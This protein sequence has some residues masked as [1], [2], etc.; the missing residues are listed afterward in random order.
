MSSS[1][2][3]EQPV[4]VP[5]DGP[6]RVAFV[7]A[8]RS[9]S[10]GNVNQIV[11]AIEGGLT[12]IRLRQINLAGNS[13]NFSLR[14]ELQ[15]SRVVIV[16]NTASFRA[17]DLEAVLRAASQQT[18]VPR[19][20]VMKQDEYLEP[21]AFDRLFVDFGV[22][23]VLSCLQP[24]DV[25]VVY[26][27]STKVGVDFR[28]MTTAYLPR[29]MIDAPVIPLPDQLRVTHR[30]QMEPV[31]L[32]LLGQQKTM[33]PTWAA[34]SIGK[35]R[36][37]WILDASSDA[38][39]RIYGGGWLDLMER[40][41]AVL[42]SESGTNAFD[43]DGSL[44]RRTRKFV[45]ER[46]RFG[47][48]N[49]AL[50]QIYT[51]EILA[52]YEGNVMYGTIAPRHLEAAVLGRPQILTPGR[53]EN[54]FLD[55]HS[56][57]FVDS[58]CSNLS[59][60]LGLV[61]DVAESARVA[62][63]ARE[64]VLSVE[65]LRLDAFLSELSTIVRELAEEGVDS[66]IIEAALTNEQEQTDAE[67]SLVLVPQD[68]TAASSRRLWSWIAGAEVN[69]LDRQIWS[70]VNLRDRF[71]GRSRDSDLTLAQEMTGNSTPP[72]T[73]AKSFGCSTPSSREVVAEWL[74]KNPASRTAPL[75]SAV[76]QRSYNE[77][78]KDTFDWSHDLVRR[79]ASFIAATSQNDIDLLIAQG[80][81]NT[82]A[83]LTV[84]G[85]SAQIVCDL[86]EPEL[87]PA[88]SDFENTDCDSELW[89]RVRAH[90]L[91]NA[92][93]V[94]TTCRSMAAF[95]ER[96]DE[97]FA[98]VVSPLGPRVGRPSSAGR[99]G[100]PVRFV[101]ITDSVRRGDGLKLVSSWKVP[102]EN[103]ELHVLLPP[104]ELV[105]SERKVAGAEGIHLRALAL[106][107]T[108]SPNLSEFDVGIVSSNPIY[109]G[110]YSLPVAFL[111]YLE[112]GLAVLAN[113]VESTTP[114][115]LGEGLGE[116]FCWRD[117]ES[118]VEAAHRLSDREIAGHFRTTVSDSY[119]FGESLGL[120]TDE[121]LRN[122]LDEGVPS[123]VKD[124]G[125][126]MSEIGKYGVVVRKVRFS[127][128]RS[129]GLEYLRLQR[130][131]GRS[132]HLTSGLERILEI[133]GRG[134][135]QQVYSRTQENK[136]LARPFHWIG[137]RFL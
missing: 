43:M 38:T 136:F 52:D 86:I 76:L 126:E 67:R 22:R 124:G 80:V 109:P 102:A 40:S 74:S 108:G 130:S 135:L 122:L 73:V 127:V 20:L 51:K 24:E 53:Y 92:S 30:G 2:Q 87:A 69:D 118:L 129:H 71:L 56:A 28:R 134:R 35:A 132:N 88:Y 113:D 44:R 105:R 14:K 5:A 4:T 61:A 117:S 49:L 19:F 77:K 131:R 32:G 50:A 106:E 64:T 21:Y 48:E 111:E 90:S 93:Q 91:Q 97:I 70:I 98:S 34:E 55:G 78:K 110:N 120:P 10:A 54:L 17:L 29:S 115:V 63:A 125:K 101:C 36:R 1:S 59:T 58:H 26:P 57:F 82:F 100:V 94:V 16:H 112:S 99:K 18:V 72:R 15:G 95:L 13:P 45:R 133:I 31:Q 107:A 62:A 60:V 65:A 89:V 137:K 25:S 81:S 75:I 114:I 41:T 84:F 66:A 39:D 33:L 37:H 3:R 7:V 11:D 104:S 12:N 68:V 46:G 119:P 121:A 103:A 6:L 8:K 96:R 116:V 47:W 27:N 42:G 9:D 23:T 83:A 85:P 128:T 79:I 123:G